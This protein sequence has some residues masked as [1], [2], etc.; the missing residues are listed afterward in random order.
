MVQAAV[1]GQVV[2]LGQVVAAVLVAQVVLLV[3]LVLQVD[4]NLSDHLR[5]D[6]DREEE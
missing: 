3:L 2:R 4:R 1:L 6:H 5:E